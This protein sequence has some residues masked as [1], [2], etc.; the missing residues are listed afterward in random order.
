MS[1]HP[2]HEERMARFARRHPARTA[3]RPAG[4][5]LPR[6][7]ARAVVCLF[8]INLVLIGSAYLLISRQV[9]DQQQRW[10]A[11]LS[12]IDQADQHAPPPRTL[13]G[14]RLAADF[15]NLRG[16]FRCG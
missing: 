4:P 12:T 15:H 13:Y 2:E 7:Q 6:G 11:V 3:R 16:E 10:C 9:A 8:L 1:E 5:G 14:R